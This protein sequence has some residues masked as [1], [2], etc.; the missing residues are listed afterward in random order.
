MTNFKILN[1]HLLGPNE[2]Q[3]GLKVMKQVHF[4]QMLLDSCILGS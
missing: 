1:P 4:W 3:R 2:Q